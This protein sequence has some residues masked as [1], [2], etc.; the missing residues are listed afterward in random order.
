MYRY[1]FKYCEN[2]FFN[3]IM[4]VIVIITMPNVSM[5]INVIFYFDIN[6][7]IFLRNI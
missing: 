1:I 6:V 5:F 4:N 2:N 3:V 7:E